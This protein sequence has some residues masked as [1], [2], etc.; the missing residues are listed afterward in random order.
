VVG[1]GA[2]TT[3]TRRDLFGAVVFRLDGEGS[4][5]ERIEVSCPTENPVFFTHDVLDDGRIAVSE[6]PYR[7]ESG[8]RVLGDY[9]VTVLR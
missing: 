3:D 4:G 1:G 7:D 2:R 5:P 9:R 6:V 8:D